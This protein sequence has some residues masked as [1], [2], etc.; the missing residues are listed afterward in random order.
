MNAAALLAGAAP[1][2]ADYFDAQRARAAEAFETLGLPTRRHEDWRYLDLATL[3]RDWVPASRAASPAAAGD[4]PALAGAY[5][6]TLID[7]VAA[8]VA[9]APAPLR[10]RP[11]REGLA[12]ARVRAA[13]ERDAFA[14]SDGVEALQRAAI[15][16]GVWID[17]PRGAEPG[18]PVHVAHVC[19]P[20]GGDAVASAALVVV[21]VGPNASLTLLETWTGGDADVLALDT[22]VVV[23]GDGARCT[24]MQAQLLAPGATWLHRGGAELGRDATYTHTIVNA[25]GT[26]ARDAFRVW[27]PQS[28]AHAEIHALYVAGPGAVADHHTRVDHAVPHCTSNQLYKGI[29]AGSGRGVFN[30]QVVVHPGAMQ[31]N[32]EQLNRN[33]LL[34]PESRVDTKPQLEIF[35]DDVKCS[36]G[37]TIGQLDRDELFYLES[38]GIG[39]D[40]ARGML[41]GGFAA[42]VLDG[43]PH[44]GLR[45]L[46]RDAVLARLRAET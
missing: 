34:H 45:S 2:G 31:T 11:L 29:L 15:G 37:A 5:T 32:A 22:A 7:G 6:V 25:G 3:R 43:I 42:E 14:E 20:G 24:H 40:D 8:P 30:G 35:N 39:A 19:S 27:L 44:T 18:V 13:L 17:V 23:I 36:H 46:A 9:D 16:E 38:R 21:T 10:V 4:A 41:I 33:L 28:G 26:L 12:D 1:T